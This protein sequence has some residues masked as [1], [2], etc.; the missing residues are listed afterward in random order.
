MRYRNLCHYS[1]LRALATHGKLFSFD[2]TKVTSRNVVVFLSTCVLN[3]LK[4]LPLYD[5]VTNSCSPPS[6]C[7]TRHQL[8]VRE[9]RE[10]CD[11]PNTGHGGRIPAR[12]DTVCSGL[13]TAS[14]RLPV[15]CVA[16]NCA[17]AVTVRQDV[18]HMESNHLHLIE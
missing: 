5:D 7:Q 3:C 15:A 1:A 2:A 18:F 6:D 17:C 13:P 16:T 12:L 11:D 4:D 10:S 9:S 8:A 14:L